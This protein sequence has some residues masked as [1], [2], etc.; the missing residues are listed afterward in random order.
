MRARRTRRFRR[1]NRPHLD[2]S[3]TGC[4]G[5]VRCGPRR[6]GVPPGR[7]AGGDNPGGGPLASM[8]PL[9]RPGR[10]PQTYNRNL[11]PDQTR[12][13]RFSFGA[14]RAMHV[15][16]GSGAGAGPS[17]PIPHDRT[18]RRLQSVEDRGERAHL[19]AS[20]S[21][22]F[23]TTRHRAR[24]P[25]ILEVAPGACLQACGRSAPLEGG[26]DKS[27]EIARF[28]RNL[29]P[30]SG[31]CKKV[32]PLGTAPVFPGINLCHGHAAHGCP[33]APRPGRIL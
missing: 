5:P 18:A 11:R 3:V 12:E 33:R 25:V 22:F 27:P 20:D 4:I 1:G 19:L 24:N 10:R 6:Q 7:G 21:H 2:G 28:S 8:A 14:R 17:G 30:V 26:K 29:S 16:I 23:S 32:H 15:R 13:S 31:R 9:D